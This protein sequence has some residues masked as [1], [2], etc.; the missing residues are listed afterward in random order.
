MLFKKPL[1][2]LELQLCGDIK[3]LISQCLV[4]A[5]Q[6]TQLQ[7]SANLGLLNKGTTS[8]IGA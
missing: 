2:V 6:G 8:L 1:E 7:P 3:H 5:I 4:H